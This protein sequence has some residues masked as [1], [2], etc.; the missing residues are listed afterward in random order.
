[1]KKLLISSAIAAVLGLTGCGGETLKDTQEDVATPAKPFSRIVFDPAESNLNVP[2]D[3][4][5]IPDGNLFDFTINI[6]ADNEVDPADPQ[7]AL[8][9]LDGWSTNHPF[10]INI[11]VPSGVEIDELTAG[12]NGSVRIFEAQQALIG[13]SATCQAMAAQVQAPT[14]PCEMGAELEFGVDFITQKTGAGEITVVPLKPLKPA[15]GYLMAVTDKLKDSDGRSVKGSTTWELVKQDPVSKPL[16]SADQKM[17]QGIV[18]TYLDAL[19]GEGLSRDSV[20]YAAYFTTQSA[21]E[22][23]DTVKQLSIAPFAKAFAQAMA[24]TNGDV[25]ASQQAAAVYLP[26]ITV[27]DAAAPDVFTAFYAGGVFSAEQ[28]AGLNQLGMTNCGAVVAGLQSSNPVVSATAQQMVGYCAASM[29]KGQISLPYYLSSTNP[30]ADWWRSACTNGFAAGSLGAEV[31]G[32]LIQAGAVGPNNDYCQVASEGLLMDLDL[33]AIGIDDPRNLTKFSPIPQVNSYQTLDVQITVPNSAITGMQKPAT[34]WPVV[35]MQ[36]GI[37][38]KKED[39][40]ALTGALSAAGY[41]TVAIDHPLHGSRGMMQDKDGDGTPDIVN[42]SDGFGGDATD[43][44]NLNSLLTARDNLRQSEADIMG[45]RLGLNAVID[46]TNPTERLLNGSD[47]SFVGHSLGAIAGTTAVAHLNTTLDEESGLNAFNGMYH[48]KAATLANPGAAVGVFLFESPTFTPLIKTGLAQSQIAEFQAYLASA[49]FQQA[50][51]DA[52]GQPTEG[53]MAFLQAQGAT[54]PTEQLAGIYG[55][56]VFSAD[57]ANAAAVAKANGLFS[58]FQFV[59]QTVL[60]SGDPVN[61]ASTIGANTHVHMIEVV[62]GNPDSQGGT[63]PSDQVIPNTTS[64]PLAGTEPLA[65]LMGLPA[66]STTTEGN[67]LVRFLEGTHSSLLDPGPSMAA[68]VEMQKQTAAFV[69]SGGAAIV[70]ENTAVVKQ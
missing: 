53:F 44:L 25:A 37:T 5:M 41:A 29:K 69:A 64:L 62:G 28:V 55:W 12:A 40:L 47:V 10:V 48:I 24:Q 11:D 51:F 43:Y 70:V 23:L 35:I 38:S 7:Y 61:F 32:N 39:M 50:L 6:L 66:V 15:Q 9:A 56:L 68:T 3:L 36:H 33:S 67:G 13:E 54:A 60:D 34:G 63:F 27:G 65:A 57:P 21:G 14:I 20:S 31:V 30:L 22:V 19:D 2:N 42:A 16:G 17:L 58:Q 45:L 1:M 8:G 52:P 59:A 49:E 46:T 4:T 26:A 18:D